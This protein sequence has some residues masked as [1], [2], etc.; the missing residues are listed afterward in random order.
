[1]LTSSLYLPFNS[2]ISNKFEFQVSFTFTDKSSAQ[3]PY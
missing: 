1:M 2:P 3:F